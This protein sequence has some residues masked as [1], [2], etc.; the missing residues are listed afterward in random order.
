MEWVFWVFI[1]AMLG[2][3]S[4]SDVSAGHRIGKKLQP[5]VDEL[6]G[7]TPSRESE[8]KDHPPAKRKTN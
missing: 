3:Y 2:L 1:I 7:A 5:F 4:W 6:F 8:S